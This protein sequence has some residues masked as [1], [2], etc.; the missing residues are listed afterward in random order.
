MEGHQ[1]R[2]EAVE[3]VEDDQLRPGLR[4]PVFQVDGPEIIPEVVRKAVRVARTEKP[5]A[6]LIEGTVLSEGRGT[7]RPFELVGA[8]GVDPPELADRLSRLRLDGVRFTP[9]L[10]RPQAQKHAGELCGGV[11]MHV[12]APAVLRSYRVGVE[13]LAVLREVA[14]ES[15]DWRAEPYEFVADRPA[16]VLFDP[17]LKIGAKLALLLRDEG[18]IA[19]AMPEGDILGFAPPLCLARDEAVTIA[20]ATRRAVDRCF[21]TA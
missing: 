5:G 14:A 20:D 2:E 17:S 18:V 9:V 1:A 10:F 15:F 3:G 6:C 12:T 4:D 8:P 16:R 21:A 19:R 7:T 13:L 11:Q